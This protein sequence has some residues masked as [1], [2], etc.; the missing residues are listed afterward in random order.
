MA[1]RLTSPFIVYSMVVNFA[2]G[3]A[4]KLTPQIPIFFVATPFLLFGGLMLLLFL[5][6]DLFGQF[7]LAYGQWLRRG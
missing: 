3:L 2:L 1:L 4:N 7:A 5:S 6:T